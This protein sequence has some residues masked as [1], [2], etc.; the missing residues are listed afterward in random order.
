MRKHIFSSAAFLLILAVLIGAATFVVQPKNN[1]QAA[2][3]HNVRANGILGEPENTIDVLVLGS[4]EVFC[5][6][7]PME[8]WKDHGITS[9]VCGTSG[10]RLYQAEEFLRDA[11]K[12]QKPKIVVLETLALYDR[13]GQ[14]EALPEMAEA[15][16]PILRYHDRWKD[17]GGR[18]LVSASAVP[19][20]SGGQGLSAV[21]GTRRGGYGG[22]YGTD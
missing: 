22:V 20:C 6:I 15:W 4:S 19:P 5:S 2:G 17:T 18:R 12:T 14:T 1:T 16:L 10:Q 9:Y 11:L 3:M 7:I 8:I 21:P 13:Y